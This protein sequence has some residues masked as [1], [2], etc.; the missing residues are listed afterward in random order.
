MIELR[1]MDDPK[2]LRLITIGLV[3]A[4]VAVGYFLFTGRFSSSNVSKTTQVSQ[5]SP[6]ASVTS[7]A[8]PSVTPTPTPVSAFNKITERTTKGGQ[9]VDTLPRTGFPGSLVAVLA[10]STMIAGW[11]LRRF[12][13]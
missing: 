5:A 11:G 12:P 10:I 3:L 8:S 6:S 1:S 9:S 13:K 4:A 2:W 7:S